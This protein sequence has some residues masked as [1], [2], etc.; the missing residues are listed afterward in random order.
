[1][2]TDAAFVKAALN[3]WNSNLNA[4]DALFASFSDEGL[5]VE[6][7]PGKNRLIYLMGHLAAV[8]D[9]MLPLLGFGERAHAEL[10]APFL[11]AKDREAAT[12]STAEVRRVWGEINATLNS[13]MAALPAADWLQKHTTVSDEDFAKEPHRN[14]YSVLLSRTNHLWYHYGQ[15][16]LAPKAT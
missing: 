5:N 2:D 12:P 13:A 8:H 14:R 10:D 6:I 16:V 15:M 1:M 11:S 4:I 3:S 7:A 9:R